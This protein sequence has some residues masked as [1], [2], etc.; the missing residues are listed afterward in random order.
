MAKLL[1]YMDLSMYEYLMRRVHAIY[2][3]TPRKKVVKTL[4]ELKET[5]ATLKATPRGLLE[6][7]DILAGGMPGLMSKWLQYYG[8]MATNLMEAYAYIMFDE[9]VEYVKN[10]VHEDDAEDDGRSTAHADSS[11]VLARTC[12][13][14]LANILRLDITD[15][16][17]NCLIETLTKQISLASDYYMDVA[18]AVM[19][20]IYSL[21]TFSTHQQAES[22][23]LKDLIPSTFLN[24]NV[25]EHMQIFDHAKLDENGLIDYS[26]T[27]SS[28]HLQFICSANFGVRGVL[29]KSSE[30]HPIWTELQTHM[31]E[32]SN[33]EFATNDL[34]S[35][36]KHN[37]LNKFASN[38]GNMW[39]KKRIFNSSLDKLLSTLLSLHL[40]PKKETMRITNI[41]TKAEAEAKKTI[42]DQARSNETKQYTF[43]SRDRKR[44][45]VRKEKTKLEKLYLKIQEDPANP[46]VNKWKEQVRKSEIRVQKYERTCV[47]SVKQVSGIYSSK[48][49]V[50]IRC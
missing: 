8:M 44:S 16:H 7:G 10:E 5:L 28:G 6:F 29:S 33:A 34:A 39:D 27:F 2:K 43:T 18:T 41:N 23:I 14:S 1:Q 35:C 38:M 50:E 42:D 19:G 26:N 32:T 3:S 48:V 36:I 31:L 4:D 40:R 9:I 49:T 30:Q 47:V 45:L 22:D 17:R 13:T 46:N 20:T 21:K 15:E 24:D 12:T 25:A 37:V 11:V